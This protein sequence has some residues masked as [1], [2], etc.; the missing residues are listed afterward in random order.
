MVLPLVG[1]GEYD[2]KNE[3]PKGINYI[4][5]PPGYYKEYYMK[6]SEFSLFDNF[7]AFSRFVR[8]EVGPALRPEICFLKEK[9]SNLWC[10]AAVKLCRA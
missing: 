2:R 5:I 6:H 3:V 1:W 7:R 9:Q 10:A 4:L 8:S